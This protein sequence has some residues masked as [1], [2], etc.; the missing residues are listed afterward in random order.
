MLAQDAARLIRVQY[1]PLLHVIEVD[2]SIKPDAP[3]IRAGSADHTG[4]R[5]DAAESRKAGE[6]PVKVVMT[7]SEVLHATGPTR[8]KIIGI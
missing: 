8:P 4:P 7:R 5:W 1:E 3:A 2:D 6:G